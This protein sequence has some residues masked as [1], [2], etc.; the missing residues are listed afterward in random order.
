MG[1]NALLVNSRSYVN[2]GERPR[3]K[4][5]LSAQLMGLLAGCP[6]GL[7]NLGLTRPVTELC[8][9]VTTPQ[10]AYL[11]M[12]L[13]QALPTGSRCPSKTSVILHM[14]A[15]RMSFITETCGGST[16]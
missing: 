3:R 13:M 10:W 12:Y 11:L 4:Q 15:K 16:M 2:S 5:K 6:C 1:P 9:N 7:T 8:N 14:T